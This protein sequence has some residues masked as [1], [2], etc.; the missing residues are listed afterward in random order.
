MR[1]N[2]EKQAVLVT[3]TVIALFIMVPWASAGSFGHHGIRI[4]GQYAATG[5]GVVLLAPFGFNPNL[6][7]INNVGIIN[8]TSREGVF[9]FKHHGT[10]SATLLDRTVT[11][12]YQGAGPI[13]PNAGSWVD[14]FDFHY[15]V[16]DDGQITITPDSGTY[17]STW[18]TGSSTGTHNIEGASF[19]GTITP[20]GKT[21]T[22]NGGAPE[23]RTLTPP[24][25][26]LPPPAPPYLLQTI[27]NSHMILISLEDERPWRD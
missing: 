10:G 15:I 22:L 14:S 11:L 21:I 16:T 8:W 19:E 18:I 26:P 2:I 7:P 13:P 9:T 5:G 12:P 4:Q 25:P 1:G 3:I 24:P 6:T 17:T 27:Y 23:V 20:D